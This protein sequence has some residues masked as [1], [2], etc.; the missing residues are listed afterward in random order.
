MRLKHTWRRLAL[1]MVMVLAGIAVGSTVV[2]ASPEPE[3]DD[4]ALRPASGTHRF[5]AATPDPAG[6]GQWTVR[7][8]RGQTG[9]DCYEVG[10]VE[11]GRF[12]NHVAGTFRAWPSDEPTGLCG[13]LGD[14]PTGTLTAAM[15]RGTG[16]GRTTDRTIVYG[17]ALPTVE[18][19]S[20]GMPDGSSRRATVDNNGTFV[21]ALK[22][23]YRLRDLDVTYQYSDGSSKRLN[24]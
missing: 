1:L 8:Y 20:I 7:R 10:Q 9:L 11:G 23:D 12:G 14:N 22:G 13:H 21:R 3:P 6:E 17:I 5:G 24:P 15:R 19:I 4:T 18:L 16:S 2:A